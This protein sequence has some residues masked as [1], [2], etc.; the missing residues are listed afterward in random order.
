MDQE[1][2]VLSL[3]S[4]LLAAGLGAATIGHLS[5]AE[6]VIRVQEES[7]CGLTI[8]P[9][10]PLVK[11]SRANHSCSYRTTE[12]DVAYQ[13]TIDAHGF[14]GDPPDP[15]ASYTVAVIGDSF[16]FGWGV[17]GSSTV[18][19]LLEDRLHRHTS[20]DDPEVLN[21][22]VISTGMRDY[23]LMLEHRVVQHDPD[24]VIILFTWDD[25]VGARMEGQV[26]A[27]VMEDLDMAWRTDEEIRQHV[28]RMSADRIEA[29]RA[30]E[31]ERILRGDSVMFEY[32]EQV[33]SI[34][35]DHGI[36]IVFAT[37]EPMEPDLRAAF[38]DWADEHNA[39]L[40]GVPPEFA[41]E[42]QHP[43]EYYTIPGPDHH[44]NR[45]GN[46]WLADHLFSS[47]DWP[48]GDRRTGCDPRSLLGDGTR[49]PL[50]P[51]GRCP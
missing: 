21:A 35:Q 34:G 23:R 13:Y 7:D 16:T 47:L 49:T 10:G 28:D 32:M 37:Y 11:A 19:S 12:L 3:A 45:L 6:Q 20:I 24:R 29:I 26:R 51:D 4:F 8:D 5:P 15:N 41:P 18:P 36:D 43:Q 25:V 42:A 33:Q 48:R 31:R 9:P 17:N 38:R 27:S 50:T 39:T 1:F 40:L 30:R 44:Y 2:A 46:R 22:G 14:R